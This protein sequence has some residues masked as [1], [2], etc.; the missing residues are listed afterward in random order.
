MDKLPNSFAIGRRRTFDNST[1]SYIDLAYPTMKSLSPEQLFNQCPLCHHIREIR[2]TMNEF[3]HNVFRLGIINSKKINL[4]FISLLVSLM[5]TLNAEENTINLKEKVAQARDLVM[6]S[7]PLSPE[8]RKK[9][10]HALLG[11]DDMITRLNSGEC[12]ITGETRQGSVIQDDISIAFDYSKNLYRFSNGGL[13]KA[14]LTPDYYFEVW[15]PYSSSV[16]VTRSAASDYKPTSVH[17]RLVDPQDIFR[18]IPVGPSKPFDYQESDFHKNIH[19][20]EIIGYE[21]LPSGQIKV[22]TTD[23]FGNTGKNRIIREYYIDPQR[24]YSV[25]HMDLNVVGT[26]PYYVHRERDITWEMINKTWV[27]TTYNLKDY[28]SENDSAAPD[29]TVTW[30]IEWNSVNKKIDP[31]LFDIDEMLSYL[32]FGAPLLTKELGP[33]SVYLG[34]IG[35]KESF[36]KQIPLPEKPSK[37]RIVFLTTGVFFIAIGLYRKFIISKRAKQSMAPEDGSA[38]WGNAGGSKK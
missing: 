27:P 38:P 20:L 23:P 1:K 15:H 9:A 4:F 29:I 6:K 24:G 35:P 17:C 8:M 11:V 3:N 34:T 7:V 10:D 21:E 12:R 19:S 5:T 30:K 32:K 31:S 36:T 26:I 2:K 18:F 28:L 25:T 14:L 22:V 37:F 33:D 13:K 16:S